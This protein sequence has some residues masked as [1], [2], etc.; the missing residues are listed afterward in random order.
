MGFGFGA[1]PAQ[2][3]G[4]AEIAVIA[5]LTVRLGWKKPRERKASLSGIRR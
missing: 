1:K 4:A 5:A 3:A 2:G